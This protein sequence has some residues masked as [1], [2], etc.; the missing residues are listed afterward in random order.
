MPDDVLDTA[1]LLTA[2]DA[3][4]RGAAEIPS[5][6]R[7]D[8]H[9]PLVWGR[10]AGGRGFVTYHDLG[11]ATGE[12]LRELVATT[13]DH[14]RSD[15]GITRV[16]WK[17]RGHDH[18]PGLHDLLVE[19]GFEPDEPETVMVGRTEDL[20][21]DVSLPDGVSIRQVSEPDDVRRMCLMADIAF[22]DESPGMAEALLSRLASGRDDMELWV[23]EADDEI[24]SCGRLEPVD[25]SEFAGLWGGATLEAWRS[26]GIY[27]V[28]TSE[29]A[30]SAL[31]RGR[32]LM[33]SDCTEFSR[34]ILERA[35][36]V[37]VTTTTPYE[38]RRG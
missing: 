29:R 2:Y 5:A 17:T 26:R 20:V 7:L 11:G 4:L 36:M 38:W 34:P 32:T 18:A 33:N 6:E 31:R 28:L 12:A 37:K 15:P 21:S 1:A 3:Q 24:V 19:H 27:R 35:G 30:R 25:D 16:E 22:G 9:G 23:A 14:Y 13:A 10:F 8:R